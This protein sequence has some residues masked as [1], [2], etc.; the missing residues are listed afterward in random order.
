M[1]RVVLCR[2][3]IDHPDEPLEQVTLCAFHAEFSLLL[4]WSDAEAAAYL[5]TLHKCQN[6]GT[7]PLM[8][9]L[10]EGDHRSRLTEALTT[11]KGINKTDAVA[12]A[13]RFG[14]FQGIAA[15]SE[16][17]LHKCPGIGDK[18]VRQLHK[19]FHTPFF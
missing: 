16:D 2:V 11:V 10:A 15:A 13:T 17:E 1:G 3:D 4:A 5:E 7:E 8:G 14:S 12:L 9:R 19:V 6:K 18:K